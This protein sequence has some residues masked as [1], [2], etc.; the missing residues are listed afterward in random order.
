MGEHAPSSSP[1]ARPAFSE[2]S[3]A[4]A[5]ACSHASLPSSFLP[6]PPACCAADPLQRSLSTLELPDVLIGGPPAHA[7]T[8]FPPPSGERSR[9][10]HCAPAAC[11]SGRDSRPLACPPECAPPRP[12][13][14]S[15]R[16]AG[17]R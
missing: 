9:V 7:S 3:G 11:P 15:P 17:F 14:A 1:R 12:H 6:L 2:T 13:L 16:R 10:G 5:R 4:C 8:T